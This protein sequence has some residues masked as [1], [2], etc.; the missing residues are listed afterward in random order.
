MHIYLGYDHAGRSLRE[1]VIMAVEALGGT[2]TDLG[3]EGDMNDDYPDFAFAVA[4][5]VAED[6]SAKG[7]LVCGAGAGMAIAANKIPGIRA[8]TADTELAAQMIRSDNDA[9]ILALAG[10]ILS[11]ELAQK[12]VTTFLSTPFEGGR[13]QRRVGKIMALEQQQSSNYQV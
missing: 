6:P 13:H 7:I 11:A 8:A 5:K 3:S 9:N 4:K 12:V 10:R 1:A 2:I